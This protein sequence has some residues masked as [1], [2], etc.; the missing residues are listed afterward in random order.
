MHGLRQAFLASDR[1]T[2]AWEV[3]RDDRI[4]RFYSDR[5]PVAVKTGPAALIHLYPLSAAAAP[6]AVDVYAAATAAELVFA[7]D[8][9]RRGL[10]NVEGVV[11][12][13]DE[14]DGA[15][16]RHVQVFRSG[17]LEAFLALDPGVGE[18]G[19][20]LPWVQQTV[21][22]L[23]PRWLPGLAQLGV[24]GPYQF[25]VT[26]VGVRG[27]RP[28]K[29]FGEHAPWGEAAREDTLLLPS[30]TIEPED[31]DQALLLTELQQL[32]HQAFGRDGRD[33]RNSQFFGPDGSH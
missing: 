5:L 33:G 8:A 24:N 22:T 32:L 6:N 26:L 20:A 18:P 23:L 12:R 15:S 10:L 17:A 21:A 14:A 11:R 16:I 13:G 25:A 30:W 1:A 31:L 7:E 19:L 3:F 9:V 28:L 27:L 2:R 4:A 29:G